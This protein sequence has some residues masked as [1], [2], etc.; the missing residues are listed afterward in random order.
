MAD[1]AEKLRAR[2]KG[3]WG[4]LNVVAD[5]A[6]FTGFVLSCVAFAP[7]QLPGGGEPDCPAGSTFTEFSYRSV[8]NENSDATD[9]E[10]MAAALSA[11]EEALQQQGIDFD[12]DTTLFSGCSKESDPLTVT[13]QYGALAFTT[14]AGK[15][16]SLREMCAVSTADTQLCQAKPDQGQTCTN[17]ELNIAVTGAI[18]GTDAADQVKESY[19]K[20]L[21]A[22]A[23]DPVGVVVGPEDTFVAD[24]ASLYD[25]MYALVTAAV[26]VALFGNLL[27]L[28]G[29]IRNR[30][31][32]NE[33]SGW[34]LGTAYVLYFIPLGLAYG[35]LYSSG[36]P[37]TAVTRQQTAAG[38]TL[39]VTALHF[40][41]GAIEAT[42]GFGG[43]NTLVGSNLDAVRLLAAGAL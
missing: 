11:F 19:Q 6:I 21:D 12:A 32:E 37:G 42:G 22:T 10:G 40:I 20:V 23:N 1:V 38:F 41:G 43:G 5:A 39:G 28:A 29:R 30:D 13:T 2:Y 8:L 16:P 14:E 31:D 17:F 9:S 26:S 35:Y 25:N 7:D 34:V 33:T 18:A 24:C 3:S 27:C 36:M 15:T 4:K